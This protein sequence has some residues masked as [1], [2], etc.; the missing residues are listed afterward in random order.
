MAAS[1]APHSDQSTI[2]FVAAAE[3][4]RQNIRSFRGGKIGDRPRA[5]ILEDIVYTKIDDTKQSVQRFVFSV[6]SARSGNALQYRFIC[7]IS[8]VGSL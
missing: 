8:P 2:A 6:G 1:S 5:E 4:P 7:V 3:A